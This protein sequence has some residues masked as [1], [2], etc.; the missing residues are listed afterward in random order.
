MVINTGKEAEQSVFHTH[1]HV[2]PYK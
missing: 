2:I 1:I